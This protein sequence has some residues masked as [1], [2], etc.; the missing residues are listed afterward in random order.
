MRLTLLCSARSGAGGGV[1]VRR[2]CAR[3]AVAAGAAAPTADATHGRLRVRRGVARVVRAAGARAV[4][5]RPSRP[6][7][8]LMAEQWSPDLAAA[9]ARTRSCAD[10]VEH[11]IGLAQA[12][13]RAGILDQAYEHFASGRA[14]RSERGRRVGRSRP[15]L[16]RLGLP[17][18][19]PG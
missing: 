9:I 18:P 19:R 13:V 1:R 17:A 8:A 10:A 6:T 14:S 12:Y 5:A 3:A 2:A 16:A 15:D 11:E 4:A 7:G